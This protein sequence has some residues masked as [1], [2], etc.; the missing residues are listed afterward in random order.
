[1]DDRQRVVLLGVRHE[2]ID[3]KALAAARRAQD[4]RVADVLHVQIECVR[5]MVRR[6]EGGERLALEMGTNTIALIE[7]EQKAQVRQVRFEQSDAPHVGG[8]LSR[9]SA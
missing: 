9:Y 8:A 3:Q 2:E 6:L 7:R 4:E 5:G 1:E